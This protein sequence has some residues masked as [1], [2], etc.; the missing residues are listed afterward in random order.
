MDAEDIIRA[1]AFVLTDA[2]GRERARLEMAPER[3]QPRLALFDDTGRRRLAI[4]LSDGG[5][6]AI[7][8]L[9]VEDRTRLYVGLSSD[10]EGC[11]LIGYD[12]DDVTNLSARTGLKSL[13]REEAQQRLDHL[14]QE[15]RSSNAEATTTPEDTLREAGIGSAR[16]ARYQRR[17]SSLLAGR[18]GENGDGSPRRRRG[19]PGAA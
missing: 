15:L 16:Q 6:P 14:E 10:G 19:R 7:R 9:D 11:G 1:R 5:C 2:A 8:F 13:S 17:L 3:E 4:Y 18:P 12:V